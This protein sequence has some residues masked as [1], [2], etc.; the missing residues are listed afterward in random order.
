MPV[1][2]IRIHELARELGIESKQVLTLTADLGIG[3]KTP[4][5]SIEDAQADRVR[6]KADQLGIRAEPIAPEPPQAATEAPAAPPAP[7]PR[8]V[9]ARAAS[10]AAPA[11]PATPPTTTPA[12]RPSPVAEP[13][14]IVRASEPIISTPTATP[15]PAP[16]PP[17][18]QAPEPSIQPTTPTKPITTP[19]ARPTPKPEAPVARVTPP[20]RT[21]APSG[22]SRPTPGAAPGNKQ[23]IPPMSASGKPIPPPPGVR[24]PPTSASGR[25]IPPPPG[26]RSTGAPSGGPG[27]S[28][29][30]AGAR[31]GG[32]GGPAGQRG[33]SARPGYGGAPRTGG[34]SGGPGR[35]GGGPGGP[36]GPG[37]RPGGPGGRPGFGPGGR[38]RPR[39]G[40]RRRRR[41]EE[42]LQERELT[43]YER[44]DL[45]VPEG[46]IVI[47]KGSTAQD[48]GPKLNRSPAHVVGFLMQQGE[49]VTATMPLS[50]DA[51]ELYAAEIGAEVVLVE[52]GTAQEAELALKYFDDDE[53]PEDMLRTRP[54]VVTVMGHVDH[55]KTTLLDKIRKTNVVAG[56][57]GGI[58]Q[59]I[60]SYQVD[61]D[62]R[63]ITFIDT[64]GHAA[65]TAMR[66]RG[67]DAT[68][69]VVLVVAADDG[70]M[71][72]TKEAISHAKAADVP[73]VVAINRMDRDAANPDR[74]K[75]QL[76]EEGLVPEDWGGDTP[77]IPIS[78]LRGD[79]IDAILEQ[80]LLQAEITL[81]DEL[82]ANPEGKCRGVVLEASLE[83]GRGPVAN[84]IVQ[85]GTL[86]VG[87]FIVAGASSGK[88]R[89][90]IDDKGGQVKEA[91]PAMPVQVLGFNETPLAGDEF[92][93]T[94]DLNTAR[95]VGELRSNARR[96]RE[97]RFT[98][99]AM[100][101]VSGGAKLEDVFQQ[102]QAGGTA[103]LNLIVK[104][105][106][107]GSLEAVTES[108][109]KLER[110]EVKVSFVHRAVGGITENDVQLAAT[111]NATIIGFNVR[112][113]R[114][115]RDS[116]DQLVVEIRTYEIIYKLLEDVEAAIVGMLTPEFEEVI[117]GEAEVRQIFA[118]PR[119]GDVA[120]C[121]VKVGHITRGSKVRFLRQGVI[122]WKGQI[123]S[124]R[125]FKDDVREVAAGFEC[126]IGLS[127][128]Q[129]LKPGDIIE[130][131]DEREIPRT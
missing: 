34:M 113:D 96:F 61:L 63:Y 55:G 76:S 78:A 83:V 23:A 120:G 40:G 65:F 112:P 71:P 33:P 35:P 87:D 127:N 6:R 56:E 51:I 79:G 122:I 105:D 126:G 104:A 129:D 13:T 1:K 59:H 18:S 29:G 42:D 117:T 44:V 110:D 81:A 75:Q 10:P 54:P 74:V 130:T 57:A 70:V 77:M 5:S 84:V 114:K 128:N 82:L 100:G 66:A 16:A 125:R 20:P 36:G 98:A 115:S 2:K 90:L 46:E 123:T 72:Q 67:A 108:L 109:R 32:Y 12:E 60:G 48:I 121:Y 14:P 68:D 22:P 119:L 11:P 106:V 124:L 39:R 41:N 47:E 21:E 102:I 25:P 97:Q 30:P 80:I 28:G 31:G 38:G 53:D 101:S 43:R 99:S 62:G 52:P 24:R 107:Q 45:P 64:P 118:V 17:P 15:T 91:L 50:E 95:T 37:G 89:S 88:V 9:A 58:T 131:Y 8:K 7:M 111:T 69:V 19:T 92:R 73:I 49:M 86:R 26:P 103:T 85:N 4:S 27:R 94:K 116:A 3:A 93:V